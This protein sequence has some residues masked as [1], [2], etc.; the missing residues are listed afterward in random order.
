MKQIIS[1]INLMSCFTS[2]NVI[3]DKIQD[4]SSMKSKTIKKI[5]NSSIK[6]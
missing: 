4:E 5:I 2:F 3:S 6:R 1:K